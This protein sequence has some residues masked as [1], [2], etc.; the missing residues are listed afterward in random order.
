MTFTNR[1]LSVTYFKIMPAVVDTVLNSNVLLT[2]IL[3]ATKKWKGETL[4]FPVKLSTNTTGT[5]FGGF[6]QFSTTSS[7]TRNLLA[8]SPAFYQ[9]TVALP[10]DELSVNAV[11]ETKVIDL[12]DVET[13]STAQD[14][15]DNLGTIAYAD[16]TGNNSKDPLGLAALVDDG[17][18][19]ANIGGLA[20]STNTTLKGTVTASSGVISLPK[21]STLYNNITSGSIKP[22]L[23]L[24]TPAVFNFYETLLQPQER[25]VKDFSIVKKGGRI[26]KP[27]Q[28]LYTG[29]G[30]TGL[31]F[32]GFPIL[33]DEK[34][35]A[36]QLAFVNEDFLDFYALPVAMTDAIKYKFVIDGNDYNTP[37][38]LGFSWSGWIKPIN[39]AS[40]VG[41]IYLGGQFI[42]QN[43]KRHGKLTGITST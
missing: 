4:K 10:L 29:T 43:P 7:Q 11:D 26:D 37:L 12:I 39:S 17:T 19:V 20:R 6:D 28:G 40:V 31:Y 32:K 33:A 41:H 5:S 24:T 25:V 14:M 36:Q 38:G 8:F 3:S 2:R 21:M 23:G 42:T 35:T 30:F 34:S 9:I 18:N 16:G 1:V 22:T 27:G 13:A 15:A